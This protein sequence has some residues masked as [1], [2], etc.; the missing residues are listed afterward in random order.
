[1][2]HKK[3][4]KSIKF[5]IGEKGNYVTKEKVLQMLKKHYAKQKE[6][7]QPR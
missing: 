6:V 1:M 4:I 2:S 3:Y 5:S 7:S